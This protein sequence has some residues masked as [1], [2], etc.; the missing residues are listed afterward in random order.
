ECSE[1]GVL[2]SHWTFSFFIVLGNTDTTITPSTR[3]LQPEIHG[4]RR[5]SCTSVVGGATPRRCWPL[6]QPLS[7]GRVLQAGHRTQGRP[8]GRQSRRG[9]PSYENLAGRRKPLSAG[10]VSQDGHQAQGAL[11]GAGP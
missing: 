6:G 11:T 9:R 4:R 10:R 7:A 8:N 1:H 5:T 2:L 3:G